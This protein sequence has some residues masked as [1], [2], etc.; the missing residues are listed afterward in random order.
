VQPVD[1]RGCLHLKSACSYIGHD[2]ILVN[3][4][5][6]DAE[7]LCGF[8]LLDVPAEEPAAANALLVNDV[9]IIPASFPKTRDLLERRGFRVRTLDLS[10]LQKAEAGMTCTSL[11]FNDEAT[12]DGAARERSRDLD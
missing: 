3:R 5:W 8:Q 9:V 6:I 10:E 1:V 11:I 4:S 12:L 2:T 7:R